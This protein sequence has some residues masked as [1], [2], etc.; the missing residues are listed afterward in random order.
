MREMV[1]I[2][3]KRQQTVGDRSAPVGADMLSAVD[4]N[5]CLACFVVDQRPFKLMLSHKQ[6]VPEA[7]IVARL[8]VGSLTVA[9]VEDGDPA[10][11]PIEAQELIE[12]L[13]ARELQIALMVAEGFAT[14]NI[15][16]KLRISER[17]VEGYV[18]NLFAKLN[19]ETRAA[20][21]YRCAAL[22]EGHR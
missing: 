9:V 15:A 20:M 17:T 18:C 7:T 6:Q 4:A 13:T 22:F 11:L 1:K 10:K 16:F 12:K 14:K 2:R 8:H 21:V 19:V 3:P 5:D